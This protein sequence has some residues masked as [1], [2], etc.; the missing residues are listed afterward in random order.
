KRLMSGLCLL[1]VA[2]VGLAQTPQPQIPAT[3]PVMQ[4]MA[5]PVMQPMAQPALQPGVQPSMPLTFYGQPQAQSP[6][7]YPNAVNSNCGGDCCAP[8]KKVCVPEP[9]TRT[10]THTCFSKTCAEFCYPKCSCCLAS[11]FS[12]CGLC[13]GCDGPYTKYFL[14]KKVHNEECP[15]FK[16]TPQYAPSCGGPIIH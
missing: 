6:V 12:C 16:C 10:I 15:T 3:Y 4:P 5:Q 13:P 9:A 1:A 7:A 11:L 8:M 14:I 2:S